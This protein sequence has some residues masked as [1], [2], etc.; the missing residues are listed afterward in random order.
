MGKSENGKQER[1]SDEYGNTVCG[2]ERG[3]T[4][5]VSRV[6]LS[7]T[8]RGGEVSDLHCVGSKA[9]RRDESERG[10]EYE[11]KE[12]RSRGDGGGGA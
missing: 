4:S 11:D 10:L 8:T 6:L 7:W 12:S 5:E 3:L 1:E 9:L 2:P